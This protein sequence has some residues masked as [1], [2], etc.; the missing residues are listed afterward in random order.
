MTSDWSIDRELVERISRATR[1]KLTEEE[2]EKFTEQ[3]KVILENFKELDTI[4]TNGIEPSFQPQPLCN[5][6][7][8]DDVDQWNWDPLENT[9]HREGKYFKGP[10]I[11]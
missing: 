4:D 1:L 5:I 2:I 11:Q 8:E 6:L 7:R 9:E 3:L 10:R